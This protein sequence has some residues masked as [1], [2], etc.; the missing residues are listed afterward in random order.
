MGRFVPRLNRFVTAWLA[1]VPFCAS[2][3]LAEGGGDRVAGLLAELAKPDQPGWEQIEEQIRLEWSKS[4]SPAMDL[5]LQR[6]Q[7]ALEAED[8]PAAIDHLSALTD[9]APDF[10]EG[11]NL[12]ATAHFRAD[13][14]GLSLDAIRRTLALNPDHYAAMTGL[15]II[16]EAL[17]MP[18]EALEVL[19]R[20]AAMNPHRDDVNDAIERLERE[21]EGRRL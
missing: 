8:I 6:G 9:H 2:V 21:T 16:L 13:N 5:L 14:Y 1:V 18:E 10:A 15:G 11:W 20:A 7:K 12:L 4:G 3:A 17:G 19:R